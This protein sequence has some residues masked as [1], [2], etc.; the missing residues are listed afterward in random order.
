[1]S[2]LCSWSR[3]WSRRGSTWDRTRFRE[4][5]SGAFRSTVRPSGA[6]G[7]WTCVRMSRYRGLSR[8]HQWDQWSRS[9]SASPMLTRDSGMDTG[10]SGESAPGLP[11][12]GGLGAGT[13][14]WV[15]AGLWGWPAYPPPAPDGGAGGHACPNA[16]AEPMSASAVTRTGVECIR[17]GLGGVRATTRGPNSEP[18]FGRRPRG[19]NSHATAANALHAAL[20]GLGRS[21]ESGSAR[22]EVP[23]IDRRSIRSR[24][25][26]TPRSVKPMKPGR[27]Q[28]IA[29][30]WNRRWGSSPRNEVRDARQGPPSRRRPR[31]RPAATGRSRPGRS[32]PGADRARPRAPRAQ[33]RRPRERPCTTPNET[34]AR[35]LPTRSGRRS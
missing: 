6:G 8:N 27:A 31:V 9:S 33:V 10:A 29:T 7:P 35:C 12:D 30:T 34:V 1:M 18:D 26:A 32:G 24:Y 21:T 23:V 22:F 3:S 25:G 2:S 17:L 13:D 15:G 5:A 28:R 4:G 20:R 14:G 19:R 16:S 11:A